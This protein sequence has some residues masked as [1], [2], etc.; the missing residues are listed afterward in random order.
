MKVIVLCKS[1]V[2]GE[3]AR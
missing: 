2:S 3:V 1:G